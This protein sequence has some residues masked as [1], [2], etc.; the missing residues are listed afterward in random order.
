MK[1]TI[2]CGYIALIGRPNVGKSSLLNRLLAQKVSIVSHKAQTTRHRILGIKT[3]DTTQAIYVDTPGWHSNRKN[4]LNRIMNKVAH[5]ATR[6]VNL[7]IF[8]MDAT[9][10]TIEDERILKM[11]SHSTAPIL[12]VI[13]KV[14]LLKNKKLLLPLIN[15]LSEKASFSKI[16]PISVLKDINIERLEAAVSDK[17]PIGPYLFEPEQTTDKNKD[18]MT[19]ET[20]REKILQ[21]IHE[22]VPYSVILDRKALILN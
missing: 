22:E 7:I 8:M 9:N 5:Q 10:W 19:A 16:I 18:F 14:D 20:I 15:D 13:N 6:D 4:T 21:L 2:H 11:L 3:T 1:K 12:L 17:L